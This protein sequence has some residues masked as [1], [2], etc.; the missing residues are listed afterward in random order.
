MTGLPWDE[1]DERLVF[2]GEQ[3]ATDGFAVALP[4]DLPPALADALARD[5]VTRLWTHQA[6][7]IRLARAGRHVGIATGTASGKTLAYAVPVL[8][9]LLV[10]PHA[11]ALYLSPTKALAQDQIGRAH[12]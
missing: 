2:R 1:G 11:R 10:E 8:E 9:K 4:D 7:A 6:E 5:G 3:P 12:V